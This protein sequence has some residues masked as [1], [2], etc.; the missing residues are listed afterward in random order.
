[1]LDLSLSAE[2]DQLTGSLRV[3]LEKESSPEAV[4]A[5][6]P[7][8]FSTRLWGHGV[9]MGIP[10][11]ATPEGEGGGGAGLLDAV[12][13][14]ELAGEFLA[15]APFIEAMV[16][17]RLLARLATASARSVLAASLADGTVLTIALEEPAGDHLEWVPAG[18]VASR[19]VALRGDEV[20]VSAD[21]PPA[22]GTAN[23]GA[24]PVAERTLAGATVLGRGH[25]AVDAWEQAVDDWRTLSAG[26]QAGAGRRALDLAIDY[27]KER[28]AFGVPIATYQ[29]VAHRLA[30]LATALDGA[31]LLA[32][33]SGWAADGAD[34]RRHELA[35]MAAVFAAEAAE[36]AATDALHFHGGYGFML[37]YDVQLY[38]RRIKAMSLLGGGIAAE[39]SQ[40]AD[41]LWGTKSKEL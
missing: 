15:P 7:V 6:E 41:H 36:R 32:R 27:T 28:R 8:G 1:M 35:M 31:R 12:L 23:L 2:Q 13:V 25:A 14:A 10:S 19:V 29:A 11:M 20:L 3:L 22:T 39:T 38:L 21:A 5:C 40:L 34:P 26:W 17:C 30:D 18:A 37:E 4:R 33:K 9:G 16:A 24:L